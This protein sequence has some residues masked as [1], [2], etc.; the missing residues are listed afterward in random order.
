M[1]CPGSRNFSAAAEPTINVDGDEGPIVRIHLPPAKSPR[2][3]GPSAADHSVDGSGSLERDRTHPNSCAP[4]P[5]WSALPVKQAWNLNSVPVGQRFELVQRV[6][7]VSADE[8]QLPQRRHEIR[9]A[10]AG[11][12]PGLGS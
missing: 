11:S 2:T 4:L 12:R 1:N 9:R 5:F 10:N 7:L 8:L 6:N 3:I